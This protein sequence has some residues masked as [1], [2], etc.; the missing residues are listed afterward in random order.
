MQL[1][2]FR[3]MADE[4]VAV[5]H[6][7][8]SKTSQ[9]RSP[10]PNDP[11]KTLV[12]TVP[13]QHYVATHRFPRTGEGLNGQQY[14]VWLLVELRRLCQIDLDGLVHALA[15]DETGT[16]LTGEGQVL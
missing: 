2:R 11:M 4:I 14:R 7:D 16:I 9:V 8:T 3:A 12:T 5:V 1:I 6:L 15:P 13:D 10:D